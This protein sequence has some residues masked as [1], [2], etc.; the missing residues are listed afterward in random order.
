MKKTLFILFPL[1]LIA[2]CVGEQGPAAP[3]MRIIQGEAQGTTYSVKYIS[4]EGDTISKG[5]ID[6]LLKVIDQSLSVWVEGSVISS[7]NRSD[8]GEISDAHFITVFMR[9]KEI[10]ALTDGAFH[11]MVM[12]L[13]RA[14]GFGPEGGEVREGMN[15]DS[16]R[17]LVT[18]DFTFSPVEGESGSYY[19]KKPGGVQ[20][21][22]NAYAQGYAV[23]MLA[24][25]AESKGLNN[26]MIE[27]GGEL[28][29]KGINDKGE[30]WR[31]GIDKP[32]ATESEREMQA[33]V[34][35]TDRSMATSGNY[36]KFY[37]KDGR[38]Y[39][40]TI[41]PATGAPAQHTLMSVTVLANN[42]TNADAFATAFMVMGEERTKAFLG[43]HPEL[44]LEVY[45][46]SDGGEEMYSIWSTPG[47][48]GMIEEN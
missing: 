10:S 16:I 19:Y 11:P 36:R 17:S 48:A 20:L 35:L 22:V 31:I 27:I 34:A 15:I 41:D 1:F 2:A 9:G 46:I 28:R 13:V 45:L 42:C 8:S 5:S 30:P 6:S 43:N 18:Y 24:H 32:L 37:M 4:S 38:K 23:D 40:H 44:N 21:D 47:M 33:V 26:Y 12:P 39:A 25:F 14:W 29:A 7:F 3:T